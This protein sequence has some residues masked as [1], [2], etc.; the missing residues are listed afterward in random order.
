MPLTAKQQRDR[1]IRTKK[2]GNCGRRA[3]VMR[4]WDGAMGLTEGW[5]GTKVPLCL[6][7]KDALDTSLASSWDDD[8]YEVFDEAMESSRELRVPRLQAHG[9]GLW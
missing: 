2:C 6:L 4:A 9:S 8:H 1:Y 7:C 5:Q 3:D